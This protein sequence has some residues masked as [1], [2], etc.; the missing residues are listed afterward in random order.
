MLEQVELPNDESLYN[1]RFYALYREYLQEPTV[2]ANHDHVFRMFEQFAPKDLRVMDLGYGLGEYSLHGH[3]T[4]YA[5][6]DLNTT[7]QVP[8][9]VQADYHDPLFFSRIPFIP[10]AFTSLFSIECCHPA[11]EKYALYEKLFKS[12]PSLQVALVGGFFYEKSRHLETVQETGGIISYQTV[13]DPSQYISDTFS[14]L[15]MHIQ[16]P[17]KMFGDDVIEVWK[18]LNRH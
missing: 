1:E 17:S 5:G 4:Q 15:R 16:T 3:Y 10:T 18:I 13:E 8:N 11:E 7:G 9:F 14:E 2:R 6:I 12:I